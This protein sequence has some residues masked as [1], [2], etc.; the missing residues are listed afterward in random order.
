MVENYAAELHT[1]IPMLDQALALYRQLAEGGHAE[2]DTGAV[3][4]LYD[5]RRI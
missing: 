4:K 2:L 1:P 3:F 5:E